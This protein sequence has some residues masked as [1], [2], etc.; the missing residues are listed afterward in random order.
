MQGAIPNR[1]DRPV[2]GLAMGAKP[3]SLRS[4]P[5]SEGIPTATLTMLTL[6]VKS[7]AGLTI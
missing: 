4:A 3:A 6:G 5:A 7:I 1:V 2:P